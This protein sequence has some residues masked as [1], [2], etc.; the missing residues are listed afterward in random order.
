MERTVIIL[1]LIFSVLAF[2]TVKA[3]TP[4]DKTKKIV[5]E[6]GFHC[7]GG[8][9]AIEKTLESVD[10]VVSYSVD[11]QKKLV[12][13]EYNPKK[14]DKDKIATEILKL[15]YSVDGKKPEKTHSCGEH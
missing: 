2:S 14:T 1:M 4:K 12:T 11:L 6:V 7:A 13:V 5:M 15:G 9:A 8:K 10:G 3:D